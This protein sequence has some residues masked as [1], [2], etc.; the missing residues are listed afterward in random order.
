[1]N[2]LTGAGW[3]RQKRMMGNTEK[4]ISNLI[5]SGKSL[6]TREQK[7]DLTDRGSTPRGSIAL[8]GTPEH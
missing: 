6:K 3:L 7:G 2:W 5:I 1:M 4:V 8:P